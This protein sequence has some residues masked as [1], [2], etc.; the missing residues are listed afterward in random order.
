[1]YFIV[2]AL[3]FSK[4]FHGFSHSFTYSLK[5]S[6]SQSRPI[7]QIRKVKSLPLPVHWRQFP[8]HTRKML[9][10]SKVAKEFG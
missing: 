4:H 5:N 3:M 10:L 2:F 1:M 6:Q 7:F 8:H 9:L